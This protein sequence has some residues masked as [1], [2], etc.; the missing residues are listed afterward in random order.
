[1]AN[2]AAVWVLGGTLV[3]ALAVFAAGGLRRVAV[4]AADGPPPLPG[5]HG[6]GFTGVP[7]RFYRRP[8]LAVIGFFVLLYALPLWLPRKE[9]GMEINYEVVFT[10]ILSQVFFV[11]LLFAL[12][13]W[14][15]PPID[16]LGLRWS[17]W[18]LVFALAPAA[19]VATWIAAAGLEYSGFNGWL[20]EWTGAPARQ[21]VVTVLTETSDPWLLALLCGMAVIVAPVTEE[22][23]FR[24]YLYPV[25]KRFAGTWPAAVF[26]A[27]V[28]AVIHQHALALLP[29]AVLGLLLVLVYEW[30]GSIWVP[31]ATHLLFNAATV[32]AQLADRFGWIELPQP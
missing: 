24:G 27:L 18:P 3:L 5:S 10:T 29:L 32:G 26:S 13:F 8:D 17:R 9:G 31:I 20:S 30:T 16:W 23:V 22:I 15:T 6:T 2:D 7:T 1:M 19:V 4:G 21:E 25:A 28:F 14:R 12:M 11:G